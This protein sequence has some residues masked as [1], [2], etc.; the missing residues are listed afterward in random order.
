M[1]KTDAK[2]L[3]VLDRIEFHYRENMT[4]T[5]GGH[6]YP[7][8]RM[9]FIQGTIVAGPIEIEFTELNNYGTPRVPPKLVFAVMHLIPATSKTTMSYIDHLN[10]YKKVG[11]IKELMSA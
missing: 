10:V 11:S 2:K 1:K 3:K 5:L 7:I 4:E 9:E 6:K 8:S